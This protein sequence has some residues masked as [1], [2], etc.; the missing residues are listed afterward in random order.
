MDHNA[1]SHKYHKKQILL[2]HHVTHETPQLVVTDQTQT[3]TQQPSTFTQ[4]DHHGLYVGPENHKTPSPSNHTTK[5]WCQHLSTHI[6][7]VSLSRDHTHL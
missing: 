2:L 4:I 5:E 3:R 6:G 1:L 7:L